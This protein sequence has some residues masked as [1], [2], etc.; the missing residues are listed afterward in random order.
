MS[1]F[2]QKPI[3][4]P[5]LASGE[6]RVYCVRLP[7]SEASL[8]ALWDVLNEEE[9]NR[10]ER[11]REGLPRDTFVAMRGI[12]RRFLAGHLSTSPENVDI[13]CLA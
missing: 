1:I 11:L 13:V 3:P 6:V 4:E 10:A 9:R 5:Q 2:A 8:A 7:A 12:L